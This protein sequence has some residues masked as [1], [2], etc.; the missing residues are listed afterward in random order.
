MTVRAGTFE[1]FARIPEYR[2]VNSETVLR[3]FGLM[4]EWRSER[5]ERLVDIATGVGTMAELFFGHLPLSW[6]RPQVICVDKSEE[7]LELARGHLTEIE[8]A[9]FLC[10][11]VEELPLPGASADVVLWGNGIHYLSEEAQQTAVAHVWR[12]LR[13]GGWFFFNTTFYEG[14]GPPE[15]QS[16]YRAQVAGAVRIL[17]DEGVSRVKSEGRPEA[18][19][20]HSPH[21]YRRLAEESGFTVI[22]VAESQVETSLSFWEAICSYRGFAAGAL[23]GYPPDKAASALQESVRIAFKEHTSNLPFIPRNWL[24]VAARKMQQETRR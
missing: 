20:Y 24:S 23:H 3:W 17:R 16:F 7:A 2:A 15:T 13:P 21:H 1:P 18:S 5:L 11:P 6:F 12:V 19:R 8:A 4:R 22:E 10:A 14:A 9:A